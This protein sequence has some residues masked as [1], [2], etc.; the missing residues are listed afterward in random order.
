MVQHHRRGCESAQHIKPGDALC[1]WLHLWSPLKLSVIAGGSRSA[2][3]LM[4]YRCSVT[5][6]VTSP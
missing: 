2:Y 5:G 3:R 4:P 1:P 6:V